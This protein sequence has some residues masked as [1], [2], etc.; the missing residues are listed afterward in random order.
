MS[1]AE[2]TLFHLLRNA[3]EQRPDAVA[4]VADGERCT[5]GDLLRRTALFAHALRKAGLRRGI[6][7]GC[8]WRSLWTRS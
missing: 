4:V 7:S 2:F 1:L 5:H 3:A 8:I 6:G